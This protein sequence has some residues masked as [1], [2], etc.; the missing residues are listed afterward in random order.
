MV[1]FLVHCQS[2]VNISVRVFLVILGTKFLMTSDHFDKFKIIDN[3]E[4]KTHVWAIT[5]KWRITGSSYLI[6]RL[7]MIQGYVL[8]L[9]FDQSHLQLIGHRQK[10]ENSCLVYNLGKSFGVHT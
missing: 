3:K 4:N 5:L 7:L 8:T 10:T 1:L 2:S 9:T 6:Q